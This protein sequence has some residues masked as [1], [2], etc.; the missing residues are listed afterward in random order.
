MNWYAPSSLNLDY[1]SEK[2]LGEDTGFMENF[3]ASY[4]HEQAENLGNSESITMMEDVNNAYTALYEYTGQ[5]R[6]DTLSD[7]GNSVAGFDLDLRDL[8]AEQDLIIKLRQQHPDDTRLR[9]YEQMIADKKP[10]LKALRERSQDV[11]DRAG[12]MGTVGTFLGTMGAH[13]KDPLFM[14]SLPFG[15]GPT[16]AKTALGRAVQVGAKEGAIAGVAEVPVSVSRYQWKEKIESPWSVWDAAE[17]TLMVMTGTGL[18][19]GVGYAIG[20]ALGWTHAA[21]VARENGLEGEAQILEKRAKKIDEA[22]AHGVDVDELLQAEDEALQKVLTYKT[23]WHGSPH[24]FEQPDLSFMGT[25]EGAQAYGHGFYTTET[26]GI[27]KTYRDDLSGQISIDGKELDFVPNSDDPLGAALLDKMKG[28]DFVQKQIHLFKSSLGDSTPDMQTWLHKYIDELEQIHG[29][30]ISRN[31]GHLYKLQ[32]SDE[33][34]DKMLDWDA[35]MSEQSEYVRAAISKSDNTLKNRISTAIDSYGES[36]VKGNWLYDVGVSDLMAS[37][38]VSQKD[39]QQAASEYLNSLGISGIKYLDG[40]SRAD[41]KGT[42]NYVVFD[43]KNITALERNGESLVDM[44]AAPK[45]PVDVSPLIQEAKKY[46]DSA[47]EFKA[48]GFDEILKDLKGV[49]RDSIV[50]IPTEKVEIKWHDDYDRALDTAKKNYDPDTAPPVDFI[51]DF[52]KDKY[53]LDDGHN[54]YVSAQRNNQPI[55]GTVQQIQ[56]NMDEL[57]DLYAK[58][59][60]TSITDIWSEAHGSGVGESPSKYNA[61]LEVPGAPTLE[62]SEVT[63]TVRSYAEVMEEF[64]AEEQIWKDFETCM[65]GLADGQ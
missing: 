11:Y 59:K 1:D 16:T 6:F 61:D 3:S 55:K 27:A 25:G 37:K 17:E 8:G 44:G 39:S 14:Y 47:E 62:G 53:I 45:E 4:D 33:N 23:V 29:K 21:K 28:D 60:G 54:R 12:V 15:A 2:E 56:G 65:V 22:N 26:P 51:Y 31:P 41:G 18:L 5:A 36:D 57:A 30:S 40:V 38:G 58:E 13:V 10:E 43:E 63:A 46:K 24:E 42:R 49:Q 9:T 32:I 7:Y 20:D 50:T 34:I 48:L 35:P 52:K 64:D 19:S